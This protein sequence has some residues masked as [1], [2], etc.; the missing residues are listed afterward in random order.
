MRVLPDVLKVLCKLGKLLLDVLDILILT[1]L[2]SRLYELEYFAPKL[3]ETLDFLRHL[4]EGSEG[5]GIQLADPVNDELGKLLLVVRIAE[6]DQFIHD[7]SHFVD[8]F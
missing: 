5:Q 6:L 1:T 2:H 8:V 4:G 7:V 3:C